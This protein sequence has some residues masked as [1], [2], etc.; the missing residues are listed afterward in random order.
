[1]KI[2]IVI[3]TTDAETVWD[4]F[5]F[6]NVALESGHEVRTFLLAKGVEITKIDDPKYEKLIKEQMEKYDSLGGE[7]VACGTCIK[8][9]KEEKWGYCPIATMK[10]L[11]EIVEWADKVMVF[12]V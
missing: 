8:I 5:R 3:A 2:G 7:I 11:L 1:M 12:S 4:I 10:D 6:A 9:R